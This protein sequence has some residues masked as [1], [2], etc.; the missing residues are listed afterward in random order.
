[1]PDSDKYQ[2]YETHLI[3]V[4]DNNGL[5]AYTFICP[6]H[7][8]MDLAWGGGKTNPKGVAVSAI[9]AHF[10]QAHRDDGLM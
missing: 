8:G 5:T 1:M 3:E 7:G 6:R 9:T 4:T 10:L 2:H